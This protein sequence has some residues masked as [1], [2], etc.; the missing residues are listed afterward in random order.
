[1]FLD[2]LGHYL[3]EAAVV[4]AIGVRAAN[5]EGLGWVVCGLVGAVFVLLQKAEQMLAA[6]P[7]DLNILFISIGQFRVQ[8]IHHDQVVLLETDAVDGF[9]HHAVIIRAVHHEPVFL[10]HQR[11]DQP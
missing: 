11:L 9:H 2:R 4:V 5:G 1:M 7:H 6:V 3:V 8:L 10:L